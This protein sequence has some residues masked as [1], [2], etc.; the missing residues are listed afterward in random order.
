MTPLS[1][2]EL[3]LNSD[4]SIYHLNLKPEHLCDTIITVGDPGRVHLVS[5]YF[6]TIRFEMNKREFIT[7]VGTLNQMP[8][9]VVSSGMGTDNVE[10][11]LTELDALANLDFKKRMVKPE[12]RKLR[13]VRIGT[14]G[15]I[16]KEIKI[17]SHVIAEHAIGF[18]TLVHFYKHRF[19]SY[20]KGI[21]TE[22]NRCI[23]FPY[24]AYCIKGSEALYTEMVSNFVEGNSITA[25]GFYGP[26]GRK[27]RAELSH[28][29][30]LD[31]IMY[32]HQDNFW[33][34]NFEMETAAYYLLGRI[35]GHQVI[36]TNAIIANRETGSFSANSTKVIDGLIK[37]VLA[38]I[39]SAG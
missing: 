27:I 34:T 26:Q 23:N 33:I 29:N 30:F 35:L 10:I 39:K 18:D 5:Q 11:L 36:S 12:F 3:V 32:F 16:R 31:E 1:A 15:S 8:I 2:S 20:E 4:G 19:T 21:A 38:Y 17:G 14:S 22:I 9:M 25:P 37:K 28:P 24:H 13:I 7:H 6:D